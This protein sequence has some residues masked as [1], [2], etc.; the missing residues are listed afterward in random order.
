MLLPHSS[1][2][3]GILLL[4]LSLVESRAEWT[5]V[6]RS[7]FDDIAPAAVGDHG[8]WTG[9]GVDGLSPEIQSETAVSGNALSLHAGDDSRKTALGH[10]P[11]TESSRVRCEFSAWFSPGGGVDFDLCWGNKPVAALFITADRLSYYDI[12]STPDRPWHPLPD[13]VV[14]RGEWVRFAV[15]VNFDTKTY[16]AEMLSPMT[17]QICK[18]VPLD[19]TLTESA[20]NSVTFTS[21]VADPVYIDDVLIQT[22]N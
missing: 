4:S 8:G 21:P 18:D 14:P 15:E 16:S 20:C 1:R 2:W 17:L 10:F 7:N 6:L 9:L 13:I 11:K 5:D 12:V 22:G 3:L 19:N